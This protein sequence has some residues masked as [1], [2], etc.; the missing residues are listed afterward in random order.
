MAPILCHFNP[1]LPTVMEADASDYAQDGVVSQR[2]PETGELHPITFWS[3]KFNLAELNYEIY[4]KE[5][6][7]IVEKMEHYRHYFEGL[8]QQTIL[9]SDHK[10]LLWFTETKIYNRRQARWAEKLSRFNFKIVFRL[11]KQ[12][13][14]P[15]ALSRRPDCTLGK[16]ASERTMTFLKPKQVD[17]SLLDSTDPILATYLLNIA[18][19]IPRTQ[20]ILI[21][22]DE[23]PAISPYLPQI[24]NPALAQSDEDSPY[25]QPFSTDA[26]GM[27]LH[28]G[29]LY[30]PAVDQIKV[31]ILQEHHDGKTAGHLAQE[32]TLELL[33]RDYYWPRMRQFVNEYINTC[34]TCIRNKVFRRAPFGNLQPLPI[35][36]GPWQ[37]VSMDFIVE[38]P[39]SEG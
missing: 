32:K 36:A 25:L 39:P 27:V 13:G 9:F 6:L 7:A 4:Y 2:D 33:T 8:G 15:D 18:T 22:L 34:E 19:E 30:I 21:T 17:T 12:G 28:N 24:W 23:D 10:N 11:G 20:R 37:S 29:R 5:M 35:P 26:Q 38:L 3:R 31:E 14:K 1:F 16:D